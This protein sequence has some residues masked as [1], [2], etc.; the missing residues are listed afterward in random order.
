[1]IRINLLGTA[2]K[3]G[4]RGGSA[5]A[6]E[7]GGGGGG[8]GALP[9]IGGG[10]ILGALVLWFGFYSPTSKKI[11]ALNASIARE[12]QVAARLAN[13]DKKYEQRNAEKLAFEKRVKVIDQLRADQS[14]PVS[15]LSALGETVNNT[16]A[17]WLNEMT[18]AGNTVNIDGQ[19]LSTHAVANL[20][21]NLKR[22]GYFKNVEIKDTA[23]DN[24]SKDM[25]MFKFTL[26]CEKAPVEQKKS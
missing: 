3:R 11:D 5:A 4:K 9:L 22:S 10:V 6:A 8:I 23:Q 2:K 15:L 24:G 12:N 19:A 25:D 16:D 7:S 21:T 20:M 1:M 17:V 14:G 26:V 13:I 18:D